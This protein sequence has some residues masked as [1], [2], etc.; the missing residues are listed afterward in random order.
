M[1]FPELTCTEE[2]TWHSVCCSVFQYTDATRSATRAIQNNFLDSSKQEAIDVLLTGSSLYG[3]LADKARAL[4]SARY[5]HGQF[6]CCQWGWAILTVTL[7]AM[8]KNVLC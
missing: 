4:L 8:L 2:I 5:L 3:D 6:C 7:E 1:N